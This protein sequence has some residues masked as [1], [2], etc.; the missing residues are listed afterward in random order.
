MLRG[1][2]ALH[3]PRWI[4][5]E[6]DAFFVAQS[7]RIARKWSMQDA[8]RVIEDDVSHH[9]D[10]LAKAKLVCFFN[11][12]E[13]HVTRERHR[14]LLAFLTDAISHAGQYLLVC[15]SLKEIYTRAESDVNVDAWVELVAEK[16]DAFLYRVR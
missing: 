12:F 15:P 11:A 14:E 2:E 16:D 3:A 13:L 5:V 7:R 6:L 9:A 4:G 8:I 1:R 10:L